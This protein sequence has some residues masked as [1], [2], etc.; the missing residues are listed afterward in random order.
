MKIEPPLMDDDRYFDFCQLN[1]KLRIE[2]TSQGEI[3]IMPPVGLESGNQELQVGFQLMA[4][5]NKDGR[6]RAFGSSVAFILPNRAGRS[7]DASWVSK[8]QLARLDQEE[9]S[10]FPHLCPEFVIEVMSP[11]DRLKTIRAKMQEWID[12]GVQLAWLVDGR[13]RMVSI[14]VPDASRK[15]S[16]SRTWWS[17]KVPSR[18]SAEDAGRLGRRLTYWVGAGA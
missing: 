12:N 11:S 16:W 14:I 18:A 7:P 17:A 5:A 9:K 2:R 10:K 13:R 15:N 3:V 4:W 6:G 1:P 8:A